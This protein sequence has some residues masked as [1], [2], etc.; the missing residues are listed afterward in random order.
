MPAKKGIRNKNKIFNFMRV[1][2]SQEIEN[3]AFGVSSSD[4]LMMDIS[5]RT[6]PRNKNSNPAK[7]YENNM[8]MVRGA[9]MDINVSNTSKKNENKA[10]KSHGVGNEIRD[11]KRI[12]PVFDKYEKGESNVTKANNENIVIREIQNINSNIISPK[13]DTYVQREIECH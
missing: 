12:S 13:I 8:S 11:D 1:K 3:S 6:D 9:G 10:K 5:N 2:N 4:D 7:I